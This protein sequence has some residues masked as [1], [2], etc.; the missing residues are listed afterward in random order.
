MPETRRLL[1]TINAWWDAI[2]ILIITG[3]TNARTE[4]ANT[5]IKQIKR[6]GRGFSNE[7]NC[8]ARILLRSAA[9]TAA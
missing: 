7:A 2:Q 6:A 3:A 5:S 1:D 9:R 8:R 4:T